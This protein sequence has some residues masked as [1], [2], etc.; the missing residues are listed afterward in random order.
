MMTRDEYKKKQ[1]EL[2][3]FMREA[4]EEPRRLADEKVRARQ[5]EFEKTIEGPHNVY[6][7]ETLPAF[8]WAKKQIEPKKEKLDKVCKDI[9]I[10]ARVK[11]NRAIADFVAWQDKIQAEFNEKTVK[12]KE[13]YDLTIAEDKEAF[14]NFVKEVEDAFTEETKPIHDEYIRM[15]KALEEQFM[16][17]NP[18][19][20][21]VVYDPDAKVRKAMNEA[22]ANASMMDEPEE[23]Q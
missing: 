7:E 15:A 13:K 3:E 5:A 18:E 11:T 10:K 22:A 6:K 21:G 20:A 17:E 8:E 14:D 19:A 4:M 16:T 2:Y 1:D 12:E 23:L 9:V